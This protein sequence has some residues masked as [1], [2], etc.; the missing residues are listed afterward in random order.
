[1]AGDGRGCWIA[2]DAARSRDSLDGGRRGW[3]GTSP[4]PSPLPAA[5]PPPMA[6]DGG[7]CGWMGGR[8]WVAPSAS[9]GCHRGASGRVVVVGVH[10]RPIDPHR[11]WLPAPLRV[12][13]DLQK[14][15]MEFFFFFFPEGGPNRIRSGAKIG[16]F[17]CQ[18]CQSRGS[19]PT[20]REFV[21][22]RCYFFS[23][24]KIF[25]KNADITAI[26]DGFLSVFR[27]RSV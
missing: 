17:F 13:V 9:I 2:S 8:V 23:P 1:M 25:G 16:V 4:H 15:G 24:G 27:G 19:D 22:K 11:S 10:A 7:C 12:A 6:V 26:N 5:S 20:R 3:F 18:G 21:E 14:I